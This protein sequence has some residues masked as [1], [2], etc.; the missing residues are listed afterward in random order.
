MLWDTY[1]YFVGPQPKVDRALKIV[2]E[3]SASWNECKTTLLENN[4]T[5]FEPSVS[6]ASPV[7]SA[8]I[9]QRM[10]TTLGLVYS[11]QDR[12]LPSAQHWSP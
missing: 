9:Y 11:V 12:I 10:P 1:P 4:F 2:Y 8:V 5:L 7:G 3:H 6:P